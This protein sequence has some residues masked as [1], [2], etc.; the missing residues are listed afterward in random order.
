MDM[1]IQQ[2]SIFEGGVPF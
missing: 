2:K 1:G